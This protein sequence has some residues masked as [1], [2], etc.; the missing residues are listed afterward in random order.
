MICNKRYRSKTET[1]FNLRLNNNRKDVNKLNALQV[2][3]HFRRTGHNRLVLHFLPFFNPWLI[4][5]MQLI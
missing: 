4:V 1:S 2:D 3:Q 5:E